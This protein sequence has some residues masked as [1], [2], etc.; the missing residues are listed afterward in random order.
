MV[1][2]NSVCVV[3]LFQIKLLSQGYSVILNFMDHCLSQYHKNTN[4]VKSK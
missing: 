4:V 1:S 2:Y 3:S